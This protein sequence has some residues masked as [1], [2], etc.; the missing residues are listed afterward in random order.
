MLFEVFQKVLNV[1]YIIILQCQ[2]KLNGVV[3]QGVNYQILFSF[4]I[5]V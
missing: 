2:D 1:D 5:S 3:L 4:L